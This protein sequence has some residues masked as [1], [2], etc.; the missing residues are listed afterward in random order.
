[1]YVTAYLSDQ[2]PFL[3]EYAQCLNKAGEYTKSNQVLAQAIK[4]LKTISYQSKISYWHR[5]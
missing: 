4:A 3:F 1:M 2:T 5:T